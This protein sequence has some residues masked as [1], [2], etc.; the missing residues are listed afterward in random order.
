MYCSNCGKEINDQAVICVHCGC[1]VT[2]KTGTQLPD[3]D[4]GGI[5]WGIL[6][7]LFPLVGF[8]LYLAFLGNRPKSAKSAGAG[9]L[10]GIIGIPL[11]CLPILVGF[12]YFNF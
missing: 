12:G 8:I 5:G 11:L 6:G 9:A 2:A 7:F 1:S 10:L 3:Y 4:K